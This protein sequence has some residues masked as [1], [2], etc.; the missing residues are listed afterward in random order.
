MRINII[1]RFIVSGGATVV[2]YQF[3]QIYFFKREGGAS[4][5]VS[6]KASI[7]KALYNKHASFYIVYVS[8]VLMSPQH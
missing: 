3:M 6:R 1:N 5:C 8:V 2:V 4:V 7:N